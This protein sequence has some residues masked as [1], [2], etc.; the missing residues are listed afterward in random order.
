MQ[1][2]DQIWTEYR[3]PLVRDLAWSIFSPPLVRSSDP[4]IASNIQLPD[5]ADR[6]FLAALQQQ[7]APLEA[8]MGAAKSTR[9]GLRFERLWQ[10]WLTHGPARPEPRLEYLFNLQIPGKGKTLGEI[11]C[12]A[13]DPGAGAL[14][15]RE[16][17]VKF[18]LGIDSARLPPE[19]Q[20]DAAFCW[21]GSNVR[22]RLDLKVRSL[23][24]RQMQIV[25]SAAG[26][27][28]LPSQWHWQRLRR[29]VIVRGRLFYPFGQTPP[30]GATG[31]IHPAHLHGQW[32][33]LSAIHSLPGAHW[34]IL[35]RQQWFAPIRIAAA[36]PEISRVLDPQSLED[37]LQKH[38][39]S[40]NQA[41]QIARMGG[42][43]DGWQELERFFVVA[44][45][46]PSTT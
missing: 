45:Q 46:W 35:K 34:C 39:Y 13:Y 27:A 16:L 41:L 23:F 17:A 28:A 31:T 12:L 10:F 15:H 11:D 19:I 22:D 29:E 30:L 38:F 20:P 18:Y 8:W 24:K 14:C 37:Q 26:V 6:Q 33:P 4:A 43:S 5:A 25:E 42:L 1:S 2:T 21:V 40:S 44:D 32:L 3:Q 36:T 9:L 7:P